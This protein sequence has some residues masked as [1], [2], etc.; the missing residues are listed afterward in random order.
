MRADGRQN[1]LE[2]EA[3][4]TSEECG[5]P[6]QRNHLEANEGQ[7]IDQDILND[8]CRD[9]VG[10]AAVPEVFYDEEENDSWSQESVRLKKSR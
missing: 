10:L 4:V 9:Q 5:E 6:E 8:Y 1:I 2:L 7:L 3:I